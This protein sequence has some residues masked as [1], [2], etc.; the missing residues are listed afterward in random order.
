MAWDQL[1]CATF[2]CNMVVVQENNCGDILQDAFNEKSISPNLRMH[3][4]TLEIQS[5]ILELEISIRLKFHL[6]WQNMTVSGT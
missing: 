4:M 3:V 1:G 5:C 6:L 2:S